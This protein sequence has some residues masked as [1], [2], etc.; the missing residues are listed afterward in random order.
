MMTNYLARSANM[1]DQSKSVDVGGVCSKNSA[2]AERDSNGNWSPSGMNCSSN[3][4]LRTD[5][6]NYRYIEEKKINI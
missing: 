3:E 6:S 1:V 5:S 4:S 2:T